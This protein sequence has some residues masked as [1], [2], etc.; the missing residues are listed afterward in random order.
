MAET[1]PTPNP[2]E[3]YEKVIAQHVF[4]PWTA[5]L[6]QR[7]APRKGDRVLDLACGTG[8]VTRSVAAMVG[9]EGSVV[10]LDISPDMLAVARRLAP[11]GGAPVEFHEGSGTEMPFPDTSFDLVL[12]QQ[13][14]QF[15]PDH[16]VG[17]NEIRRV[18]APGGRAA[19]SVWRDIEAQPFMKAM[20]GV[21]AKHVAPGALSLPFSLSDG[22]YLERLAK[23]AGFAEVNVQGASMSNKAGDPDTVAPMMMQGAAAV[24]PQFAAM[25]EEQRRAAIEGMRADLVQAVRPFV[26]A[27]ELVLDTATNVLLARR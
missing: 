23:N 8:I 10:G 7:A 12:C 25:T 13:G 4:A 15:F 14:L 2:A 20:D 9:S 1:S 21:V 27:G 11:T 22:T 6:L 3:A 17:L 18:L 5:D 26:D 19:V 24:L 16:Q